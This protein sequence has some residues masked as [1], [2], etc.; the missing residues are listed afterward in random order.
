MG[1]A[2]ADLAFE[3]GDVSQVSVYRD[4]LWLTTDEGKVYT[5]TLMEEWLIFEIA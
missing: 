1:T 2:W 4:Q 3:F 5:R